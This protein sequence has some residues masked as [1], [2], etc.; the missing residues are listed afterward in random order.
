VARRAMV[1]VVLSA[2]VAGSV[3]GL[4]VELSGRTGRPHLLVPL[5]TTLVLLSYPIVGALV[6]RGRSHV[7]GW[8]LLVLGLLLAASN[9]WVASLAVIGPAPSAPVRVLLALGATTF[10]LF[11]MLLHLLAYRIPDGRSLGGWWRV[12]ERV[13]VGGVATV[14][15]AMALTPALEVGV[16]ELRLPITNPL[17]FPGAEVVRRAAELLAPLL[18]G[19]SV[20][21]S[22]ASVVVRFRRSSGIERQQLRWLTTGLLFVVGSFPVVAGATVLLF[23]WAATEPVAGTYVVLLFAVPPVGLGVAI[24]RYRLYDLDRL[25][26]R[27]VGYLVVTALLL[28]IYAG[29][30]LGLGTV[31]RPL[32]GEE[33][34]LVVAVATLLAAAMFRPLRRRVQGQVDRRFNRR[35]VDA[36]QVV[37]ELAR[38][39]RDEL[40][41][42]AVAGDLRRAVVEV[43]EPTAARVVVL[44]RD[45]RPDRPAARSEHGDG[46]TPGVRERTGHARRDATGPGA[47]AAVGRTGRGTS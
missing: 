8:A 28:A 46:A 30:V 12:L 25:V 21:A 20:V 27:T 39:L 18:L 13:G 11:A 19:P 22:A 29:A 16:G 14:V 32:V 37:A 23:G 2:T 41:P 24:T 33:R 5:A 10:P 47:A 6:V 36:E 1:A 26:S 7:V 15:V 3:A 38:R 35:R 43:L 4:W 34:D 9:L 42:G 17:A 45:V 44:D 40:D 31:V